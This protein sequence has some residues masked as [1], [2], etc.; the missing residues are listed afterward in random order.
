M[1]LLCAVAFNFYFSTRFSHIDSRV[2]F[3]WRDLVVADYPLSIAFNT[4][5]NKIRTILSEMS[6]QLDV[7]IR[8]V[9][10]SGK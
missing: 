8:L 1:F 9:V 5:C 4:V 6:V 2:S 10:W 7:L 3:N